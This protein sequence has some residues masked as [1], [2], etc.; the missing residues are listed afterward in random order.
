MDSD[1]EG[2]DD[3][4]EIVLQNDSIAYFDTYK[5]SVFAIAEH[6]LYP[7]LIATGGSEGDADDTPGKGYVFNTSAAVSRPVLPLSYV[8]N[9]SATP[10]T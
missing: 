2:P 6:P 8:S 4:E 5:D 10:N 3:N 9:P 1:G 7:N